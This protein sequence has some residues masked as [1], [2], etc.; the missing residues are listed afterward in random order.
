VREGGNEWKRKQA[1]GFS[2]IGM[3]HWLGAMN[4]FLTIKKIMCNF[5]AK[6]QK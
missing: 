2:A 4:F 6:Y 1:R 3:E 5:A